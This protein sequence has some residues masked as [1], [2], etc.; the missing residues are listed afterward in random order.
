MPVIRFGAPGVGA[1]GRA[2]ELARR[3]LLT[4]A[5]MSSELVPGR[6]QK[7]KVLVTFGTRPVGTALVRY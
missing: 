5:W 2:S 4:R 6:I 7:L 1:P 3:K